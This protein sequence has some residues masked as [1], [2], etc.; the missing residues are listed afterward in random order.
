MTDYKALEKK[1]EDLEYIAIKLRNYASAF[2]LVGNDKMYSELKVLSNRIEYDAKE[3]R[4]LRY[5]K[6]DAP[7]IGMTVDKSH[8]YI[9]PPEY[10]EEC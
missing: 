10:C 7:S 9:G 3:I 2:G 6:H 4:G 5:A 8:A 1:L